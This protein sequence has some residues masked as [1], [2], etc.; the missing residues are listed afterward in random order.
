M[1]CNARCSKLTVGQLRVQHDQVYIDEYLERFMY[2]K[3]KVLLCK[4]P[5]D[6]LQICYHYIHLSFYK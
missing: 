4:S 2:R 3:F 5:L 6:K 1:Y